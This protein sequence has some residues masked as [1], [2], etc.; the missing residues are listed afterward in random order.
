MML[1]L[2]GVRTPDTAYT[3]LHCV[4]E[5]R[6]V[7]RLLLLSDCKSLSSCCASAG[8][9]RVAAAQPDAEHIVKAAAALRG[10][11]RACGVGTPA[12]M[13]LTIRLPHAWWPDGLRASLSGGLPDNDTSEY[14]SH[15][16]KTAIRCPTRRA[17]TNR[18]VRFI[19]SA[20]IV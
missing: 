6:T 17:G 4:L 15:V 12:D 13:K 9:A 14:N 19:I 20:S 18:I 5:G 10:R 8:R 16:L 11:S 1:E 3:Q 7:Q 2:T